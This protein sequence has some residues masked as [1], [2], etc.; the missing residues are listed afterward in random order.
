MSNPTAHH[1]SLELLCE[2]IRGKLQDQTLSMEIESH[3]ES[4]SECCKQLATVNADK[5]EELAFGQP[6]EMLWK[7][8]RFTPENRDLSPKL[9]ALIEGQ[10]RFSLERE[11]GRGS[12]GIVYAAKHKLLDRLVALKVVESDEVV[13]PQ[14]ISSFLANVRASSSV[15]HPNIATVYDAEIVDGNLVIVSEFV[16]GISLLDLVQTKG[17]L[18]PIRACEIAI[19]IAKALKA[20]HEKSI[21]HRNLKPSNVL[22]DE[23]GGIKLVDFGVMRPE[24]DA[25]EESREPRPGVFL[26]TPSFMAPEQTKDGNKFD[27]RSDMFSLGCILYFLMVGRSPKSWN[28]WTVFSNQQSIRI[29]GSIDKGRIPT[30]LV[31]ILQSMLDLNPASRIPTMRRFIEVLEPYVKRQANTNQSSVSA[32]TSVSKRN[33]F[34]IKFKFN[35]WLAL[36]MIPLFI[37]LAIFIMSK[38]WSNKINSLRESVFVETEVENPSLCFMG[39]IAVGYSSRLYES[40]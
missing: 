20:A 3:I 36:L 8:H 19:E 35:L 28:P 18:E 13:T 40:R 29:G 15:T 23:T 10:E 31:I 9:R 5:F 30:Y 14:V 2:F 37:M 39:S 11:V 22:I 38:G 7:V 1:P 12:L 26:G 24:Y 4:C 25:A 16:K 33:R 17:T 27:E 32:T 21:T 6:S 34:P